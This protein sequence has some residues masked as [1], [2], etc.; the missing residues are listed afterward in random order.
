MCQC[1]KIILLVIF[2][3]FAKKNDRFE[4]FKMT[5]FFFLKKF[6]CKF[7]IK[8]CNIKNYI[9]TSYF[10]AKVEEI[11]FLF[12]VLLFSK[13]QLRFNIFK[14][15]LFCFFDKFRSQICGR[16]FLIKELKNDIVLLCQHR[17]KIYYS[18]Y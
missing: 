1:E 4:K 9:T 6:C 5:S 3:C 18:I 2:Y 14:T 15:R 11:L 7:V 12:I 10:C 13:K 17:I 8:Y 16:L